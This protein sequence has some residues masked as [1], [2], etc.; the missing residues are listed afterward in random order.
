MVR[1][2]IFAFICTLS[3]HVSAQQ[4]CNAELLKAEYKITQLN[5]HSNEPSEQ[6]KHLVLVRM[7]G[8]VAQQHRELNITE[9]WEHSKANKIKPYRMFDAYQRAIEYQ[10]GESVHGRVERD[11]SY[12]NQLISDRLLSHMQ[13]VQ[14][15]SEGCERVQY[16][17]AQH[18][19]TQ[20]NIE[21]IPEQKLLRKLEKTSANS[22]ET[23][24]L[25][26]HAN[27]L[28]E[29]KAFFDIR[30]NY[31]ST[32]FAD[33]GDDHTDPFLLNMVNLGFIE[34]GASG[35]YDDRGN[36]IAGQHSHTH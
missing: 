6:S 8:M 4:Q 17:Q 33:I 10:P 13:V 11:W 12:R 22:V 25:V 1:L 14:E 18:G 28:G 21:W 16:M 23:W 35:F 31:H 30:M 5:K 3:V 7:P 19:D 26:N 29:I 36:A 2:F 15:V 9:I 24:E 32:D 20:I 34:A 27:D